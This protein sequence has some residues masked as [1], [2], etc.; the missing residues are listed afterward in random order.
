MLDL[1]SSQARNF[2][3]LPHGIKSADLLWRLK[4][5]LYQLQPYYTDTHFLN[6]YEEKNVKQRLLLQ[7]VAI[8]TMGPFLTCPA[9]HSAQAELSFMRTD[10]NHAV[11]KV[12][13]AQI[14]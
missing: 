1:L 6:A 12:G 10:S 9:Q 14:S 7:Q 5:I 4:K 8:S 3:E 11:F 13:K 2:L